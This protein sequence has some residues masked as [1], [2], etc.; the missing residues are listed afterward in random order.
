MII[1]AH[2][3]FTLHTA[4]TSYQLAVGPEGILLHTYYGP[5]LPDDAPALRDARPPHMDPGCWPDLL[6]R[7]FS[8]PGTADYRT[9]PCIPEYADGSEAAEL[10]FAGAAVCPGKPALPGLPAFR[11]GAG[12]ETLTVTLRD[13][14]GLVVELRYSVYEKEDLITRS[15]L[16]RN[17]SDRPLT[18][19]KA[20]SL[21][22]D[23]APRPL[24]LLTLN[25][26]WAAERTPERAP[27]RCGVQ[28]IG[29]TRGIP[30]HGHNP[31]VL[32]CS[33]DA[34][35]TAGE[36]WGF[37]L[38]YSGNF[39]IEAERADAG[40]RLVMGIHP[41]HFHWTLAPGESFAA[42]EAAMVYSDKG[43]GEMSRRFH[44]AIR[45]R[46]LPPRW[47]DMAAPRPVLIN[48]WEAFYFDYTQS[49][50]LRLAA[51]AKKA[52]IDLLVVDDGWFRGRNGTDSSL[53]DWT[54]DPRK[55]PEGLPGLCRRLNEMDLE[56]GL[57]VEP[58]AVN[59]DS[60]LYRAH[61]DW[62]LAVPGRTPQQ[63]RQ[64]YTL[65]FSRPEVVDGIWTQ[66]E[67]ILR[68]CPIRYLKWDMN[69]PLSDVYS[70]ALPAARQ[71]EV[72]HRYVLGVYELQR[73]ITETFPGLL[74]ENCAGGG[75]RFD[76]GMLYYSPQ[77]WCSDNTD[78]SARLVIQ[79]GTSLFY[80][81]CTMG[82][83][84]STVPNHCTG[85]VSTPEAR[86]AAALCGTFGFELDLTGYTEEELAALRPYVAWYRAHGALLRGGELYR[87]VPPD[88]A[89]RGAA[90]MIAAADGSEAA[91]FAVGTAL[92]GSH[93][94]AS[95][96]FAPRLPL[97]ALD[98][99]AT[100]EDEEGTR[101]TGA[102]LCAQGLA[103][104]GPHGQMPAK[105]WYLKK[106]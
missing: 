33:P 27:L 78:A 64:Q 57:W 24:E 71:G 26:T 43:I 104:P 56:M 4:H 55:L 98:P 106:V 30:G 99:A 49:D 70:A 101:Y 1:S 62:A 74:L 81:G 45:T 94:T 53:G 85:H 105:L 100:Y 86:M 89:G 93:G 8:A 40:E 48:S 103:L 76:C 59:P 77:I 102:Q 63:I 14:G 67:A 91:V 5:R 61:P 72:Y 18:L 13:S 51:A 22:L 19:Q 50:L 66:L 10:R 2:D 60:E 65:D 54:A 16:Y 80:P 23:F 96:N 87:L 75:A 68:S 6:P 25:G 28:S 44:A 38:V 88:P 69:R 11:G 47:Q 20:A 82:A 73:R 84:F 29:S 3:C 46:L 34:T 97:P 58:E 21:C 36:C 39:L 37:A 17:E 35:E 41:Y 95:A 79:Y 7:E 15:V 32:L 52:D 90:W 9:P 92:S 12:V 42:P 83:H 31:A